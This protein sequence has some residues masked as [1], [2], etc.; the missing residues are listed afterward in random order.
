MSKKSEALVADMLDNR[1]SYTSTATNATNTPEVKAA[2]GGAKDMVH[3]DSFH[4][5]L[6]N[7][8]TLTFT[9]TGVI[10]DASLAGTVLAQFPMVVNGTTV[11]QVSP[12]GFHLMATQGK[13]FFFTTDTVQPSLT[14]T[15]NA[16]GW[17]DQSTNY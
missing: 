10:R 8:N 17:T 1:W 11:A 12:Y 3:M 6:T 14:S 9:M 16:A 15:V 7:E 13:G 2:P 4:W 5:M